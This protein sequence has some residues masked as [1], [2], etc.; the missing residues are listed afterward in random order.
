MGI[1]Q[2]CY[3]CLCALSSLSKASSTAQVHGDWSVVEASWSIGRVVALEAV[4]II[5]LL[6]LF[7]DKSSHLVIVS[8]P[9][10]LVYGLLGDDAVDCS[11]LEYL[12]IVAGR[13]FEDVSSYAW[14]QSS[15]KVPVGR[16]ISK[17]VS[18]FSG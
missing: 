8:F 12:V 16:G 6:S 9:K 18:G 15:Y 2:L 13:R 17:C 14:D 11:L 3:A 7:W 5:P 1:L 10:D 4:L